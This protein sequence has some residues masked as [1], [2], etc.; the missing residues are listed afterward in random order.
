MLSEAENVMDYVPFGYLLALVPLI[1]VA[2]VPGTVATSTTISNNQFLVYRVHQIDMPHGT[3]GSRNSIFNL[4]AITPGHITDTFIRKCAL[5]KLSEILSENKDIF[6][7]K[8]LSQSL[9]SAV[10]IIYNDLGDGLTTQ[11]ILNLQAIEK[12]LLTNETSLPIYLVKENDEINRLYDEYL[13]AKET[14]KPKFYDFL[15]KNVFYDSHQFVVTGPPPLAVDDAVIS[16]IQVHFL[17]NR[18]NLFYSITPFYIR[19]N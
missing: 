8:V 12:I 11:E 7:N 19:L 18:S 10:L 3:F 2:S 4:E 14:S 6:L 13:Q 5:F 16:S 15:L 9:V 17:N 1:L